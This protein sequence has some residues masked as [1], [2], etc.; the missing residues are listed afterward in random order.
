[1]PTYHDITAPDGM[2]TGTDAKHMGTD[3]SSNKLLSPPSTQIRCECE[4]GCCNAE[5]SVSQHG[6][7]LHDGAILKSF[8][9]IAAKGFGQAWG[10]TRSFFQQLRCGGFAQG[11]YWLT[12]QVPY[13]TKDAVKDQFVFVRDGR[14]IAW[15]DETTLDVQYG[16]HHALSHDSTN[17]E[18]DLALDDGTLLI[19]K[20]FDQDEPGRLVKLKTPGNQEITFQSYTSDG[21]VS[22]L[23]RAYTEGSSTTT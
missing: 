2:Y 10:H 7:R 5:R 23:Q 8:V 4:C 16:L 17:D 3:G 11:V 22:E 9:D 6:V 12:D 1:M 14:S 18:Y 20:D 15:F 21:Q 19:F 13:L